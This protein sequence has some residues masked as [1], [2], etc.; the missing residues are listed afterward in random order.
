MDAQRQ[1]SY[2][3]LVIGSASNDERRERPST[4]GISSPRLE[5][6]ELNNPI[7]IQDRSFNEDGSLLF[8]SNGPFPV[9]LTELLLSPAERADILIFPC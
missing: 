5:C 3:L 6:M 1:G 2:H 8:P 9:T 7:V 4:A